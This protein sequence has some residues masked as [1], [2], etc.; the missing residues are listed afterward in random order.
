MYIS[1][2][3]FAFIGLMFFVGILLWLN[4]I[5]HGI[6]SLAILVVYWLYNRIKDPKDLIKKD[7]DSLI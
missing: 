7:P 2:K 4:W 6:P 3:F 1:L 5:L